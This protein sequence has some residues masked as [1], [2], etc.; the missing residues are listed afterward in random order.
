MCTN[1][2][3][4]GVLALK[5]AGGLGVSNST[6]CSSSEENICEVG[7]RMVPM[8]WQQQNLEI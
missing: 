8:D 7:L 1:L 6:L 5:R 4:G 3:W 2:F